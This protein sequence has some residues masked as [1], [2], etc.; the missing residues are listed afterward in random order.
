MHDY[1]CNGICSDACLNSKVMADFSGVD[2]SSS[3][4][5]GMVS[6]AG[7][8]QEQMMPLMAPVCA[9][10]CFQTMASK[11]VTFEKKEQQ[12]MNDG[13]QSS[14]GNDSAAE[15]EE[16]QGSAE[17]HFNLG[18]AT[19]DEG[20]NCMDKMMATMGGMDE[21]SSEET[22]F[23]A[24]RTVTDIVGLGCCFGTMAVQ[25][26]WDEP[27]KTETPEQKSQR[28]TEE[29]DQLDFFGQVAECP[30]GA[31]ALAPCTKNAMVDMTQVASEVQVKIDFETM[32]ADEKK[33]T[34]Q[35]VRSAIA[36]DLGVQEKQVIVYVQTNDA[37]RLD[38]G[39]ANIEYSITLNP[40]NAEDANVEQ[41]INGGA[42]KPA[43]IITKATAAGNTPTLAA[44]TS[45]D[46]APS[47]VAASTTTTATPPAALVPGAGD[48]GMSTGS[49]VGIVVGALCAV[50]AVSVGALMV[51]TKSRQGQAPAQTTQAKA[52]T[53]E[54]S[55]PASTL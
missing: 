13:K 45:S 6:E 54:M 27:P 43:T 53:Q 37:R 22:D 40:K 7:S 26:A 16:A 39:M 51:M 25:T 55:N 31:G 41:K 50:A 17:E 52:T 38:D 12:C 35:V 46:V 47:T 42:V 28:E 44:L 34:K 9:D 36:E 10:I 23:C 8:S 24:S 1:I 2:E 19:N 29:L 49:I 3:Q 11:M 21:D 32:P 33:A 48:S 20:E 14:S 30:G 15:G 18:C 4:E 5:G